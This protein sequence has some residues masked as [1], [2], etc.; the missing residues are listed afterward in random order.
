MKNININSLII[1]K[2]CTRKKI[3]VSKKYKQI[4]LFYTIK[5]NQRIQTEKNLHNNYNL[6]GKLLSFR[7]LWN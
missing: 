3:V 1:T 6:G 2:Y 5:N 7:A 4:T